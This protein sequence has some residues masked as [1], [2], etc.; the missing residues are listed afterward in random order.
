MEKESLDLHIMWHVDALL[1]AFPITI[2]TTVNKEGSI[3]AAPY[4]L[5]VPFC[6]S[7]K[8][9]QMLLISNKSWHTAKNIMATNE[10]VLNYPRAEQLKDITITSH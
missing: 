1:H 6:S 2:V 9:P 3:N 8:N 5:V 7:P 10:F 4:S